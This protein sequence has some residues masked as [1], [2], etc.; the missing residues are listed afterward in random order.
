MQIPPI[1]DFRQ[2]DG[3]AYGPSWWVDP[4]GA[5]FTLSIPDGDEWGEP[6]AP[7]YRIATSV[8][9]E[10]DE[11]TGKAVEF[12]DRVVDFRKAGIAGEPYLIGV[13][14]DA[15]T[16]KVTIE[17]AWDTNIYAAWSVTFFWR[18]EPSPWRWPTGMGLRS[19]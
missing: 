14:C 7:S 16:E 12:L 11:I 8:L 3:M 10:L 2:Q 9:A 6:H 15:R 18:D 13:H 19:R 4:R 1:E 17:M 5:D